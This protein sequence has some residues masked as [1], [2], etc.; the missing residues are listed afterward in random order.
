MKKIIYVSGSRADFGM[1]KHSLLKIKDDP[2]IELKV[3]VTGMHLDKSRGYSYQEVKD[4]GLNII[5]SNIE[6]KGDSD[7]DMVRF[8]SDFSRELG[9]ILKEEEPFAMLLLGDRIE[10]LAA[11]AVSS[12][13]KIPIIHVHGGDVSGT[14]DD[15]A[16]NAITKM[17]ELHLTANNASMNR[18]LMMGEEK[19]RVFH[20]GSPALENIEED[21]NISLEELKEKLDLEDKRIITVVFHPSTYED[22]KKM[23]IETINALKHYPHQKIII[24][25]NTDAGSSEIV[26]EINRICLDKDFH[27]YSNLK[28]KAYLSLLKNSDVLAGNTSSGIIEA[29]SLK[30]P[31]VSIGERQKGRVRGNNVIEAE[32]NQESIRKAMDIALSADY[33]KKIDNNPYGDG[34]FTEKLVSIIEKF[35]DKKDLL[36]KRNYD[37]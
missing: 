6:F 20:T 15:K 5:K 26:D 28:R 25:P 10:A 2:N 29:P 16:R 21:S 3:I 22:S 35:N 7:Y 17:A 27:Y 13:M 14:V 19:W 31:F 24:Y 37:E 34:S 9:D 30:L 32:G 1:M 36:N 12:Y 8:I 11:A 33:R 23:F 4:T 18:I